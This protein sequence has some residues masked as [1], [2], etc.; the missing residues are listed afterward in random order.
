MAMGIVILISVNN[1]NEFNAL[2]SFYP[3][4]GAYAASNQA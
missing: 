3:I 2:N 1:T 4:R